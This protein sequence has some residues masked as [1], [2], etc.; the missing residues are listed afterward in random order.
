MPEKSS[1]NGFRSVETILAF[2]VKGEKFFQDSLF[3]IE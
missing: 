1:Q 2:A 3:F